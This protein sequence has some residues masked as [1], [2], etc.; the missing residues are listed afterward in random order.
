MASN[1]SRT[2]SLTY[3]ADIL[4]RKPRVDKIPC[5]GPCKIPYDLANF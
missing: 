4:K 3:D 2:L 1:P 5:K